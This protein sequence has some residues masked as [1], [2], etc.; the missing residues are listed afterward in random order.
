MEVN[1]IASKFGKFCNDVYSAWDKYVSVHN[2]SD[3][4]CFYAVLNVLKQ[5]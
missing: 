3:L 4:I 5:T 1:G 2:T